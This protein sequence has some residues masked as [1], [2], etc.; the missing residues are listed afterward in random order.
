MPTPAE[1]KLAPTSNFLPLRYGLKYGN[2]KGVQFSHFGYHCKSDLHNHRPPSSMD[3]TVADITSCVEAS[4]G[5]PRQSAP[6]ILV[7]T[8]VT[9][10][11]LAL[12]TNGKG[13]GHVV[14]VLVG[15]CEVVSAHSISVD[16]EDYSCK[17]GILLTIFDR[18]GW[19]A[20]AIAEASIPEI[21]ETIF[22]SA[23]WDAQG[24]VADMKE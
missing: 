22:E 4:R 2:V 8:Q 12:K 14:R 1:A 11:L 15:M 17:T 3:C 5:L 24:Q 13:P 18:A 21:V 23:S 20:Q 9:L 10:M 19:L 16:T 6:S 7:D